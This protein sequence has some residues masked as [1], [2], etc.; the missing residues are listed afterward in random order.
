MGRG[1]VTQAVGSKIRKARDGAQ[2]LVDDAP[3]GT[4][5]EPPTAKAQKQCGSA[6]AAEQ[7]GAAAG[8]PVADGPDGGDADRDDPFLVALAEHPHRVTL[9]VDVVDVEPAYLADAGAARIEQLE[10]RSITK[11][12]GSLVG[13]GL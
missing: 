7:P 2:T 8:Q 3:G 12:G 11:P 6:R 5:V 1:G 9:E 13:G 4:R 10:Q